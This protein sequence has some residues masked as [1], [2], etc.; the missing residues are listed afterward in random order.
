M[1]EGFAIK[2]LAIGPTLRYIVTVSFLEHLFMLQQ[3]HII[4][5]S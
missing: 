2:W 5:I 3:N 4:K 1:K